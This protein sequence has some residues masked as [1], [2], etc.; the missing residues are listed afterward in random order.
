MFDDLEIIAFALFTACLSFLE[1]WRVKEECEFQVLRR[2]ILYACALQAW[3][4]SPR[5]LA[6]STSMTM[7]QTHGGGGTRASGGAMSRPG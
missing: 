2:R 4:A 6:R 1:T 3:A 5:S 7:R